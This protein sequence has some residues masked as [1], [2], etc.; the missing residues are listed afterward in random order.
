M[1]VPGIV[2]TECAVL[3]G[4]GSWRQLEGYGIGAINFTKAEMF[5]NSYGWLISFL[6]KKRVLVHGLLGHHACIL[7]TGVV[8]IFQNETPTG[9]ENAFTS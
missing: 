3:I 1:F 8:Q 4:L 6:L 7:L 2:V 5:W 9:E